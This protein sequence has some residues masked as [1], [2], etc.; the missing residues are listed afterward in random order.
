MRELSLLLRRAMAESPSKWIEEY[1]GMHDEPEKLLSGLSR[2]HAPDDPPG[3]AEA[4]PD[5]VQVLRDMADG[6]K[7]WKARAA[8][9]LCISRQK[10]DRLLKKHGI[11]AP[12]RE[13][14]E[15]A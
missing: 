6:S 7:G 11:E 8:R 12:K 4:A 13:D 3:A 2:P 14:P 10:V 15:R 5:P 1:P 9:A